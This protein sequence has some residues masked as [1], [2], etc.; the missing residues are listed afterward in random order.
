MKRI[1][2]DVPFAFWI[3]SAIDSSV[4]LQT[5]PQSK[6]STIF[7]VI[8]ISVTITGFATAKNSATLEQLR[9]R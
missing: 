9:G 5:K 1:S 7:D 3:D 6:V 2:L 8:S 4:G